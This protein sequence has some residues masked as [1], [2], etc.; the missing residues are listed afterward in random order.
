[1]KHPRQVMNGY[2]STTNENFYNV[3]TFKIHCE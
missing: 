1:M 2:L 3:K